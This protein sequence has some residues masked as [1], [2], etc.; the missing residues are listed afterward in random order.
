MGYRFDP[1]KDAWLK[2]TR[3]LGFEAVIEALEARGA[4]WLRAH[5]HQARYPGQWMAAV[6][7]AGYVW[8]VPF[9]LAADGTVLLRTIYPSRQ[10]TG[11]HRKASES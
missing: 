2:A 8:L 7:I 3:G 4:L 11:A 1:T 6:E 9:D 5:R 10:A